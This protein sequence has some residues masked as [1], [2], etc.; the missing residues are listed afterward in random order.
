MADIISEAFAASGYDKVDNA[1]GEVI[2]PAA[3]RETQATPVADKAPADPPK[4]DLPPAP[5]K[6]EPKFDMNTWLSEKFKG[7]FKSEDDLIKAITD[8]KSLSTR[9]TEAEQKLR[10]FETKSKEN[11][12]A[13]DYIKGLNEFV[14][15]GG[16][17]AIY[18]KVQSID[19]AKMDNREASVMRLRVQYG[20][21]KADAE[22][23]VD[24]KYKIGEGYDMTDPDVRE[25]QID[26]KIDGDQ[27]KEY[28]SKYKTDSLVP[29]GEKIQQEAERTK[30]QQ[31]EGWNPITGKVLEGLKQV[32]IPIDEKGANIQFAVPQETLDHLQEHLKNVLATTD[33]QPDADGQNLMKEILLREVFFQHQKDIARMIATKKDEQWIKQ[34]S[35]PSALRQETDTPA[36]AKTA[37]EELAEM[38]AKS[39]G[40]KLKK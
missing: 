11:P 31:L 16:D 39:T 15:K 26:L 36:P 24:R 19:V 5:P 2:L 40:F 10:D 13:N 35:N 23:R 29:P 14:K 30:A 12:F 1:T 8:S 28:L 9:Y 20:L 3:G 37:D 25:A 38:I 27:A 18:N 34:T 7:E 22:F 33:I 6:E 32:E 17:P 4:V 21:T